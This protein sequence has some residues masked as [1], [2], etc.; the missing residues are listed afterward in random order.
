[1]KERTETLNKVTGRRGIKRERGR[2]H[3][4][5]VNLFCGSQRLQTPLMTGL[6][7]ILSAL[8]LAVALPLTT[9]HSLVK[10]RRGTRHH[11]PRLLTHTHKHTH[12]VEREPV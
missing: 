6:H 4:E 8:A 10:V 12:T 2:E 5:G 1:M 9:P 3:K 11:G 7:V